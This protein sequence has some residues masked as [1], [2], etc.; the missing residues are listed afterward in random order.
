MMA[1][2]DGD[3]CHCV[4]GFFILFRHPDNAIFFAI[5]K[6]YYIWGIAWDLKVQSNVNCKII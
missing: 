5:N 4:L 1:S 3:C 2:M 6:C